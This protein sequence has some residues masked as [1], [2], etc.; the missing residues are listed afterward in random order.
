MVPPG[1][2]VAAVHG[3]GGPCHGCRTWSWGTDCGGTIGSVTGPI[4]CM[5]IVLYT[6]EHRWYSGGKR[7]YGMNDGIYLPERNGNRTEIVVMAYTLIVLTNSF[8]LSLLHS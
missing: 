7:R 8:L 1:P 2:S 3:P 5:P 4:N 6:C